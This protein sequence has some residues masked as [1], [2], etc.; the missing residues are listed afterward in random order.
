MSFKLSH[1]HGAN[2]KNRPE[3]KIAAAGRRNAISR[4]N[5]SFHLI[6]EFQRRQ[7]Q[8]ASRQNASGIKIPKL[9]NQNWKMVG[10]PNSGSCITQPGF[11]PSMDLAWKLSLTTPTKKVAGTNALATRIAMCRQIGASPQRNK[12][13]RTVERARKVWTWNNGIEA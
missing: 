9:S 7:K 12:Q 1:S 5:F 3:I 2:L 13:K 8:T 4:G 11:Q 10:R 6:P